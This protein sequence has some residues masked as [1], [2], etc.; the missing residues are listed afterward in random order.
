RRWERGS[1]LGRVSAC[2]RAGATC[3]TGV[4]PPCRGHDARASARIV[5]PFRSAPE[6]ERVETVPAHPALHLLACLAHRT[7][8]GGH[9]SAVLFEERRQLVPPLLVFGSERWRAGG[10]RRRRTD[11]LRQMIDLDR[12]TA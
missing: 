9:V 2:F 10:A 7:R 12:R 8:D 4:A 1:R 5:S 3:G 6:R 11:R